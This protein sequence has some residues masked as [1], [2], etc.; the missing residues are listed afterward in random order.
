MFL[1][2]DV[3]QVAAIGGR[4][5]ALGDAG[6][7]NGFNALLALQVPH[8]RR[9]GGR[10]IYLD[11][12]YQRSLSCIGGGD[13]HRVKA[14]AAGHRHHGKNAVGVAQAAVERKFAQE[15][16]GFVG[17]VDLARAEQD[18]HGDGQVVGGAGPF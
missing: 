10:G 7:G 5:R 8:Q 9:Q 15:K 1:P 18:S 2:P 16:G 3:G 17:Q 14:L 6:K 13:V 4:A 12:L 11:S